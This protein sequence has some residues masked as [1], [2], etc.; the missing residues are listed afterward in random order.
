VAYEDYMTTSFRC[1]RV[2]GVICKRL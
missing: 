2:V 1:T